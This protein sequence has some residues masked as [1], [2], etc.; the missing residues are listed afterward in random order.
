MA[1]TESYVRSFDITYNIVGP[2]LDHP[3]DNH[4]VI[5]FM[6]MLVQPFPLEHMITLLP[7]LLVPPNAP[8]TCL[9]R[10]YNF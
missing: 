4:Y 10:I 2:P 9:K 7:L 1:T 6:V 3:L 8:L 5:I